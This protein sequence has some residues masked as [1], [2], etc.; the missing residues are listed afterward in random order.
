M[1]NGGLRIVDRT[2]PILRPLISTV[3]NLFLQVK[4]RNTS[5]LKALT[6]TENKKGESNLRSSF[7]FGFGFH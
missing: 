3:I 1:G 2:P 4:G 5:N 6:G 7:E